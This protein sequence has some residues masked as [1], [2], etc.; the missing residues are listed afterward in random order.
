MAVNLTTLITSHL[1]EAVT[2]SGERWKA[3]DVALAI[4]GLLQGNHQGNM[5][6]VAQDLT[7]LLGEL[8]TAEQLAE[9]YNQR[10]TSEDKFV[11]GGSAE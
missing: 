4:N 8:C 1:N 7:T 6:L 2:S 5:G 9:Y 11:I 3:K 10:V